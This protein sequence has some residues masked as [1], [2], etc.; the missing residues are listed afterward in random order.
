MSRPPCAICQ[1]AGL[2]FALMA[3]A[4]AMVPVIAGVPV[5]GISAVSGVI[6][7]ASIAIVVASRGHR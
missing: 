7:L 5:R 4:V 3:L 6:V 2:T 1:A